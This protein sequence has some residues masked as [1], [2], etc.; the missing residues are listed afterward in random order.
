MKRA[1]L[2][3]ALFLLVV[4]AVG[5]AYVYHTSGAQED[6]ESGLSPSTAGTASTPSSGSATSQKDQSDLVHQL[7]SGASAIVY[8]DVAQLR[9]SA[10]AKELAALAPTSDQDPQY[11]AFVRATGFDYS[12]DLDRA[13]MALWPHTAP[14][15]VLVLAEGRFDRKKIA[16][17]ALQTGRVTKEGGL[18]I[19]D[20]PE[21][22]SDRRIR[23]AFLAP[24][25]LAL[26]DGPALAAVLRPAGA[27]NLD[28]AMS[29]RVAQVSGASIFSVARTENLAQDIGLDDSR[30]AQLAR[31]LKSIRSISL[32]GQPAASDFNISANAECDSALDALQLMTLLDG[33]RWMGRAELADPKVQQQIGPQ[34]RPLDELLKA[35]S[36]THSGRT[37]RLRAQLTEQ[38]L[39]IAAGPPAANSAA[40]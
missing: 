31:M 15:T 39:G 27:N 8:A 25:R 18:E 36:L 33:L 12:R 13:T 23:F 37:L 5:L 9:A 6:D 11:T 24:N 4:L 7:P 17:Y 28:P 32:A 34:W 40:Q 29:A 22:G 19:Y 10:F 3:L 35:A 2:I 26:A 30:S 1:L 16:N 21:Q 38:M 20:V 14:T